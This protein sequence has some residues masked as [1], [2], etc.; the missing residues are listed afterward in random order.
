[1]LGLLGGAAGLLLERGWDIIAAVL[2]TGAAA[3]A[4]TAYAAV[5]RQGGPEAVDG[6]TEAAALMVLALAVLSGLG[7]LRLASATGAILVL[8]LREK[9]TIQRFVRRIGEVELRAALQFAVLALVL[10]PI[11]PE[12]PYGP[13]GGV[14]PRE[15]WM[16][17]LLVS[18]LNFAGYLA[19]RATSVAIGTTLTGLLGGLFSSTAVALTF[20]RQSRDHPGAGA[21]LG[22]GVVAACTILFPRLLVLTLA[23]QPSLVG[24]LLPFFLP[25]VAV[26]A[27]AMGLGL[28]R[29]ERSSEAAPPVSRNPLNLGSAIALAAIFQA[30]LMLMAFVGERFGRAGILATAAMVGVTDTDAVALSMCHLAATPELITLAAT[31]VTVAVLAN[32]LLKLGVVLTVG[33]GAYRR[34]TG[35]W[36]AMLAAAVTL[37]LWFGGR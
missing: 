20:S 11:L 19:R 35:L 36:L 23:L 17:V 9:S 25:P 21:S 2:V 26:G 24:A 6:T 1:M 13:L 12:G 27:L 22:L 8:A 5:A 32:T 33:V 31:A 14:R 18:A 15:L 34:Q 10:L 37:G 29:A 3:L 16:V 28:R 30:V 4:V 7:L